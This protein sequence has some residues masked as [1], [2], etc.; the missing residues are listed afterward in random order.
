MTATH[1]A[2]E[3]LHPL[4]VAVSDLNMYDR[5]PRRGKV[6]AIRESL[7]TNGQYRPVVANKPTGQV[8]AGNHTL[9][10]AQELGW[11]HIATTWV[12]VDEE[13]AARIVLVDNRSNDIATYDDAVLAEL[14]ASLDSLEGTGY[15]PDD[16]SDLQELLND[17]SWADGPADGSQAKDENFWPKIALQVSPDTFDAWH[18]A[19]NAQEGASDVDKLEAHLRQYGFLT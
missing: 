9:Q 14:L 1:S 12:D 18:A 10:A 16:L 7:S 11:T 5:N 15:A 17:A 4:L 6:D 19:L 13:T 2:H 3:S 8:L